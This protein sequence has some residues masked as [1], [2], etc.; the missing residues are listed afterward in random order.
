MSLPDYDA[1]L[2]EPFQQRC[3]KEDLDEMDEMDCEN[4]TDDEDD[5][6]SAA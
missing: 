1:W 5:D 4:E 2:E 6:E 3:R